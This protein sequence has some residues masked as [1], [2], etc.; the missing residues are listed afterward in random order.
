MNYIKSFNIIGVLWKSRDLIR[1]I[2]V[3]DVM[4]RYKGTYL[5]LLWSIILP[6]FMLSIYTFVFSVVFKAKWGIS[7]SESRTEFA[8]TMFCG[9]IPY[10]LF[11]DCINK[12]PGLITSNQ[13]YV[14]KVVFPLEI[15][16]VTVLFSATIHALISFIILFVGVFIF[17]GTTTWT[18]VFLPVIL[19]PLFAMI[20]GFSW[21]LASLGVFV[22]DIGYSVGVI[23]QVLFFLSP[24]FY[25]ISA[26]PEKF[27]LFMLFNPLTIIIENLRSV[28]IWGKMPDWNGILIV[29]V[30]SL[31][32]LFTGYFWFM[33]TKKAFADVI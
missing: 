21:F 14:K 33:K 23:I 13:N 7:V 9:M 16:P 25:P 2:T 12:A 18:I 32:I 11:S 3:R 5:G 28:V 10:M 26:V 31:F 6:L 20:L 24:I 15:L 22:R 4:A 1:Q 29:A 30:F 8:L 17:I 27:K 19:L